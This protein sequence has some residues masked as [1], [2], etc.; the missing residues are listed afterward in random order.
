MVRLLRRHIL[1]TAEDLPRNFDLGKEKVFPHFKNNKYD[2]FD[3]GQSGVDSDLLDNLVSNPESQ[4]FFYSRHVF[5]N[6]TI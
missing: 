2:L 6:Y 4:T 3:W 5:C 1:L